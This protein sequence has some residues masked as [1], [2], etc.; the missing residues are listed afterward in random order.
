VLTSLSWSLGDTVHNKGDI[1][2][3][4]LLGNADGLTA[5]GNGLVNTLIGNA[6]SNTL[7]GAGGADL[8]RGLA[9]SDFYGVDNAGDVVDET[10]GSGI[11][12]VV[13]S[14]N[15]NLGDAVHNKGD[16]EQLQIVGTA[17]TATGNGLANLLIGND[18]ANVLD[19]AA[20]ADTMRGGANNDLYY[21]DN[22]L[23]VVDESVAGSGGIDQVRTSNISVY[24]SD[25]AHFLGNIES[26]L[27]L[28]SLNL[29]AVGNALANTLTGNSGNNVLYGGDGRDFLTGAAGDDAFRFDTIGQSA[30]NVNR[31]VITDFDDVAGAA[32]DTINVSGIDANSLIG[33]NQAFVLL[34]ADGASFTGAGQ[35]RW[36]TSGGNTFVEGNVDGNLGADFSIQLTG[37]KTLTSDDFLL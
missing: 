13:S 6:G 18:L 5:T 23:D 15:W 20:G 31:D 4:T 22:Y 19:G 12:R 2:N 11:D 35:L 32:G 28:G 3:M 1:E 33:G 8:L 14:I 25:T 29:S 37:L 34:A 16:V 24:L 17:T 21:V 10:G 7:D 9:G 36:Y 26:V 30:P 27:L